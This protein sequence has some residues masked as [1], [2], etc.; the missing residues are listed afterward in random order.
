MEDN[1]PD[2]NQ[3]PPK[4]DEQP[5]PI[6]VLVYLE[7]GQDIWIKNDPYQEKFTLVGIET[8][9][10]RTT[11][12]IIADKYG[13]ERSLYDFQCTLTQGPVEGPPPDDMDDDEE[14]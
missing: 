3:I 9:A 12:F 4:S 8:R 11:K 2:D 1:K 7:W 14:D 6:R 13:K 10:K 5:K